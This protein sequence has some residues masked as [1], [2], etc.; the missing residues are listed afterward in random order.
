MFSASRAP[1][2]DPIV[3]PGGTIAGFARPAIA[4]GG[5]AVH[6]LGV[7]ILAQEDFLRKDHAGMGGIVGIWFHQGHRTMFGTGIDASNE[8]IGH[9]LWGLIQELNGK[10]IMA[11]NPGLAGLQEMA[12][13]PEPQGR[14][15][16]STGSRNDGHGGGHVRV[17]LSSNKVR[18]TRT[19]LCDTA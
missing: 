5:F 8:G 9:P 1:G 18:Q 3:K 10:R 6:H 13:A 4:P 16:W 12:N 2:F 14:H 7:N 19:R 15:E 11:D 17:I